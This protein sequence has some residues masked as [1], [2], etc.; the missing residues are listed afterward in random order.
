[1]GVLIN[2]NNQILLIHLYKTSKGYEAWKKDFL[3]NQKMREK[4]GIKVLAFG[5]SEMDNDHVYNVIDVP[6]LEVMQNLKK[7]PKMT[8]LREQAGVN[9]ET[10]EMITIKE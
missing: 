9:S 1:M 6:S 7:E 2:I 4:H 3:E 5:Q 10:Q 8:K